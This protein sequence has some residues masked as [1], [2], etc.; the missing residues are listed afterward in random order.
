[1]GGG[2]VRLTLAPSFAVRDTYT[3]PGQ[4]VV[5]RAE[6]KDAYFVLAGD[7]GEATWEL[8]LRPSGDAALAAL[9]TSSGGSVEVSEAQGPGFPMEEAEGRPLLV[10]VTGSGIAAGRPVVRARVRAGA[11]K[12]T[13]L[14]FG[15]RRLSDLPLGS[16]LED[17][18]RTGV[19]VTVCLSREPV[20]EGRKGLAAGYVQDVARANARSS[21]HAPKMIFAAGVR[22][23]ID[24][25]RLLSA[26]LG[27]QE[28]DVRTNY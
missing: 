13:E 21:T 14:L 28:R 3:R 26:E 5:M 2:L 10:V 24:A 15:V 16:E 23:M 11:A 6:G 9:T 12:T 19:E 22:E 18:S 8:V 4:Y 17:W 27:V 20:Q 1:V 25:V 7:V